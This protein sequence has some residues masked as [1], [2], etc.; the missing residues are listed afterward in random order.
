MSM[1]VVAATVFITTLLVSLGSD[2]GITTAKADDPGT[3]TEAPAL[4]G[5]LYLLNAI[6]TTTPI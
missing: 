3:G 6:I 5:K 1:H 2:S 4:F